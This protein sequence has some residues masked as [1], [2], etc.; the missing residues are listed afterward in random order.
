MV[1]GLDGDNETFILVT[2]CLE[3]PEAYCSK[4][5]KHV[6]FIRGGKVIP[7]KDITLSERE[8]TIVMRHFFALRAALSNLYEV[9]HG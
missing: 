7:S 1:S 6:G 4:E 5:Q 3:P 2:V 8:Q 9:N